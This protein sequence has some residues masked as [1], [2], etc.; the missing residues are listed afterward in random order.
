MSCNKTKQ[1]VHGW[2]Y[3]YIYRERV[4]EREMKRERKRSRFIEIF[5]L[6]DHDALLNKHK[7]DI[8]SPWHALRYLIF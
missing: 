8:I 7:V 6:D 2:H 5:Q 3:I 4:R 1:S